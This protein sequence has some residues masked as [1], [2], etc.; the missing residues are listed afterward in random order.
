MS[1]RPRPRQPHRASGR[2]H[3]QRTC[4]GKTRYRDRDEA[5]GAMRA[6][7]QS[8]RLMKELKRAYECPTCNGWHLTSRAHWTDR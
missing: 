3:T 8:A 2:H 5:L 7:N 6:V 1:A 4:R